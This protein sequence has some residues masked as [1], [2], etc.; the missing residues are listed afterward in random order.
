MHSVL[1]EEINH[2]FLYFQV[3]FQNR[4]AR[5]NNK[6][7][8]EEENR[9]H[10][11]ERPQ[12]TQ[13]SQEGQIA[14]PERKLYGMEYTEKY[15]DTNKTC[16]LPLQTRS[17]LH[18]NNFG[19]PQ[20]F[21][22]MWPNHCQTTGVVAPSYCR[23]S[24]DITQPQL[25]PYIKPQWFPSS[26]LPHAASPLE[27]HSPEHTSACASASEPDTSVDQEFSLQNFLDEFQPCWTEA[28][29]NSFG[30]SDDLLF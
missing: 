23:N 26:N 7:T 27:T 15:E 1:K 14:Q 24:F 18:M 10:H 25:Q 8:P 2:F 11:I 22:Y 4:R 16:A 20:P 13:I 21:S 28:V 19:G 12:F 29:T 30:V 3:W 9:L 6:N 5:K 17:H